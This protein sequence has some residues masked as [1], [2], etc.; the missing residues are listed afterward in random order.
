MTGILSAEATKAALDAEL[1]L[2]R[3]AAFEDVAEI[4]EAATI[5]EDRKQFA[6]AYRRLVGIHPENRQEFCEALERIRDG[7]GL[8]VQDLIDILNRR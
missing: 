8:P 2:E 7:G 6:E 4:Y 3:V 5:A 1:R